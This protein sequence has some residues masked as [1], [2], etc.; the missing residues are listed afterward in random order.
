MARFQPSV[1]SN[2]PKKKLDKLDLDFSGMKIGPTPAQAGVIVAAGAAPFLSAA[3]FGW[4]YGVPGALLGFLVPAIAMPFVVTG[5]LTL[6]G[7]M[8][9]E[10]AKNAVKAQW[11]SLFKRPFDPK[12]KLTAGMHTGHAGWVV[13]AVAPLGAARLLVKPDGTVSILAAD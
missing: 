1:Y 8:S 6:M 13:D 3:V 12:T 10:K 9:S 5:A 7:P 11:S 4:K 2:P